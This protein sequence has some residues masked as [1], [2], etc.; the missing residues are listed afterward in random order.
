MGWPSTTQPRTM[1]P[2]YCLTAFHFIIQPEQAAHV[3]YFINK[4]LEVGPSWKIKFHI[5]EIPI[6]LNTNPLRTI[7]GAKKGVEL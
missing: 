2:K 5:G 6:D 7:F 3:P 4:R 1:Q